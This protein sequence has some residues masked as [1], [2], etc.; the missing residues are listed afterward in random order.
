MF[1]MILSY[2]C[3]VFVEKSFNGIF[4]HYTS[5]Q[6]PHG[7]IAWPLKL[8]IIFDILLLKLIQFNIIFIIKI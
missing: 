7:L 1:N 5:T 6:V 8:F 3:I 4:R 2:L